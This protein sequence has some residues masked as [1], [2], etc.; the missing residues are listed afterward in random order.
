MADNLTN[1]TFP[2]DDIDDT[3]QHQGGN[4]NV[5]QNLTNE[6]RSKGG[7]ASSSQQDMIKLGQTGGSTSQQSS[8]AHQLTEEERS[9]GGSH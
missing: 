2:S 9:K 8:N 3:K 7:K 6:D 5:S 4:Q 1:T